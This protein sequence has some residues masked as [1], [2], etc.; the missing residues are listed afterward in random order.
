M[1]VPCAY[2]LGMC[3]S[4]PSILLG[5]PVLL[6]L[7]AIVWLFPHRASWK[8][9]R[10]MPLEASKQWQM[11]IWWKTTPA[12]LALIGITLRCVF[13]LSSR[14]PQ[15]KEAPAAH[16][17]VRL[18]NSP[19]IKILP[20]LSYS[21]T[22]LLGFPRINNQRKNV[23][24]NSWYEVSFLGNTN[25]GSTFVQIRKEK[26]RPHYLVQEKRVGLPFWHQ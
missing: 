21:P 6:W 9:W 17:A 18:D 2:F 7:R 19:F 12:S 10:I 5:L 25:E 1:S 14:I 20:F 13:H 8:C 16:R 3:L 26:Q 22:L 24:S 15:H 11:K 4:L 23:Y